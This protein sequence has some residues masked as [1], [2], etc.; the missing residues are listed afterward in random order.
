MDP[1]TRRFLLCGSVKERVKAKQVG[2]PVVTRRP[3]ATSKGIGQL[4]RYCWRRVEVVGPGATTD[5]WAG[6]DF[7]V[8]VAAEHAPY[9]ASAMVVV[10]RGRGRPPAGVADAAEFLS[11]PGA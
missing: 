7:G 11:K 8:A 5:M 2:A 3:C 1:G 9:E 6:F 10:D 4:Q